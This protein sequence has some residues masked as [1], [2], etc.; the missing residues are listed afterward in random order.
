MKNIKANLFIFLKDGLGR[1]GF[2]VKDF[3]VGADV[4]LEELGDVDDDGDDDDRNDVLEQALPASLGGVDRLAV[5]DR[6]VHCDVPLCKQV[7]F[8]GKVFTKIRL[9]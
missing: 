5:V 8:F 7:N 1:V 2:R 9:G 3:V 4:R 6:V